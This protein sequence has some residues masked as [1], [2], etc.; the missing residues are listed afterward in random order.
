MQDAIELEPRITIQA[1]IWRQIAEIH[2]RRGAYSAAHDDLTRA[3][4]CLVGIED[5]VPMAR[6]RIARSMLAVARGAPAEAR[7]LGAEAIALLT[8][9]PGTPL[10]RAAAYRAVGIAAASEDDLAVAGEA[11]TRALVAAQ[12]GKDDLLSATISL[13]LGS[14]LALQHHTNKALALHR[15]ALAFYERIGAKRGIALACNNLGDLCW[16][17]G[18]GDWEEASA[19][20]QRARR[21]YE[22][23]GDQAGL[24]LALR[25]LGEA[26][27]RLGQFEIAESVL[28][29]ARELADQLDDDDLRSDVDRNLAQLTMAQKAA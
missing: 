2:R 3:E 26:H 6:V 5:P 18:E 23:V 16:R 8:N 29:R 14:V 9:V 10:D 25:N 22:E 7:L 11:F 21:L 4:S 13:N 19:Y 1:D 15:E 24:A 20:W 27:V 17:D 12:I 28:V